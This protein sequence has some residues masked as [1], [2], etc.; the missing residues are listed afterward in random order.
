MF[1]IGDFS[2]IARVSCRLL[3]YY[4]ELGLLKPAIVDSASGY[5]FYSA[6]QLPQLSRI[7]VLKELGL[8]L[9]Q[10]GRVVG[11]G[12]SP[13]ELRAMLLVRRVDIEQ[14]L[15]TEA[16]RL[17][18][19]EVRIAEIESGGNFAL[20][21]VLVRSEPSHQVLTLRQT[22]RSFSEARGIIRQLVNTVPRLL[23]GPAL[24]SLIAIAHSAE[25]EPDAIDVELGYT[26]N[27]DLDRAAPIVDG[28][29]MQFRRLAGVPHMAVCV[30]VGLPEQ[31]HLVTAKIGRYVEANGYALAGP[32]RELFLRA[33]EPDRMENSVVE[34][35]FPIERSSGTS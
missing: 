13:A 6:S 21:D 4:D 1:R 34:M 2:R 3:R 10:I 25:F 33:P 32:S 16:E 11:D 31:A 7:L 30:R 12:V 14:N 15:A 35:Q 5:R 17:R 18:Q 9:E 26:L 19:I 28:V 20:E 27:G 24:G 8:S 22:M 29:P 23:P